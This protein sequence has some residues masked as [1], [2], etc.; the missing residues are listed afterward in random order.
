MGAA[1]LAGSLASAAPPALARQDADAGPSWRAGAPAILPWSLMRQTLYDPKREITWP[2]SL[3]RF[4]GR[5]V[6]L[7]GYVLPNFGAQDPSDVLLSANHPSS[8]F[9]GP[10]DMTAIVEVYMPG[11]DPKEWPGLPV[12]MTGTFHL[13]RTPRDLRALYRLTGK[14]WRPLRVWVQD[15][16]GAVEEQLDAESDRP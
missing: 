14:S 3:R 11:F 13:S 15:F 6:R 2:D 16:P 12:E 7:E 8:L 5:E 1:I 4:D 9:C 10:S